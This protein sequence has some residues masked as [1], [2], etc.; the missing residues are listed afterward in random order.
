MPFVQRV[1]QRDRHANVLEGVLPGRR[2]G[3]LRGRQPPTSSITSTASSCPAAPSATPALHAGL[4]ALEDEAYHEHEVA[5]ITRGARAAPSAAARP[6]PAAYPSHGNFVAVDCAE[7]PGGAEGLAGAVLATASSCGRSGRSSGSA[8]AARERERRARRRAGP[9]GSPRDPRRRPLR[10]TSSATDRNPPAFAWPGGAAVVVNL[11]LVYEEGSEGSVL[12]G[13]DFNEGWGEY[14][15]PGVQPPQRDRGTE[16]HYEYGSRAGVWRLA[17][18]FDEARRA[19]DG[20]RGGGRARAQPGGA[21]V[22]ARA[23][24][25]PARP[26]LALDPALGDAARRGA[27]APAPR[28]SRP[29]SACSASARTAGTARSWPSESTRELLV[30]EGGFLYDSDGCADDVP[31]YTNV[32]GEPFL[33]VPYS[34]TYNDSRFL[35]NPG[36][37]SPR[38]FLD[39]LVMGLDELVHEGPPAMMTVAVHARWSGQAA[40]AAVVRDFPRARTREAGGGV[41]APARHRPL[42]AGAVPARGRRPGKEAE[43]PLTAR[44]SSAAA[45][46]RRAAAAS[47]RSSKRK[48]GAETLSAA[49]TRPGRVA[50]RGRRG[51]EAGLELL[52]HDRKALP[53]RLRDGRGS[54]AHEAERFELLGAEIGDEDA[55][56]RCR[57]DRRQAA[58]TRRTRAASPAGDSESSVSTHVALAHRQ[59]DAL[60][61]RRHELAQHRPCCVEQAPVARPGGQAEDAPAQAI[62]ERSAGRARPSRAPRASRACGRAGSCRRRRA[63]RSRTTPGA[64]GSHRRKSASASSTARPRPSA[65]VPW[66]T[67]GSRQ[68]EESLQDDPARRVVVVPRLGMELRAPPGPVAGGDRLDTAGRARREQPEIRRAARFTSSS[69]R[70]RTS[71][72]AQQPLSRSVLVDDLDGREAV[73]RASRD[74]PTVPPRARTRFCIPAQMP[75]TGPSNSRRQREVTLERGR[76]V[77]CPTGRSSRRGRARRRRAAPAAVVGSASRPAAGERR[78]P[79]AV[80]L[81]GAEALLA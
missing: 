66:F 18:I 26:R 21:G 54:R 77:R 9:G 36:F 30:E 76:V 1:R 8:S 68:L 20:V 74:G 56:G 50:D 7:R 58:D 32:H 38:D 22:D 4:A 57:R 67:D 5:R 46:T 52:P 78:E 16:A 41:H 71:N 14:A 48:R 69:W 49:T 24:P 35:M 44:E 43:P 2:Q 25:R 13:D 37:A 23:R 55:P 62:A 81:V 73:R 39:T 11:V 31:Y 47:S 80:G 70:L 10:A 51:D 45:T 34:K 15:A 72:E 60:A 75:S 12:W 63:R 3:R 29:T 40:R 6:G 17:R 61:E 33:V 53:P 65:A 19:G 59:V 28:A 42:V 79:H 64:V 27:R